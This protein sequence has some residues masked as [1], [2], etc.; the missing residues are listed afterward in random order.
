MNLLQI[1]S[2]VCEFQLTRGKNPL[3]VKMVQN[4]AE[5]PAE[6]QGKK[7]VMEVGSQELSK[8]N[9]S[10]KNKVVRLKK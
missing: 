4:L 9:H 10:P 5:N 3:K 8:T 6:K 7:V 1:H 2:K